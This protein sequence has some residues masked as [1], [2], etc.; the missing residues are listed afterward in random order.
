MAN[1]GNVEL[2]VP[3]AERQITRSNVE[4]YSPEEY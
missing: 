3:R 2:A 1:L 4:H